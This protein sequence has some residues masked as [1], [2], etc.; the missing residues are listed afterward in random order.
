MPLLVT[1]VIVNLC[2]MDFSVCH[3]YLGVS[4][5][6]ESF[7]SMGVIHVHGSHSCPWESF[8]PRQEC[9]GSHSCLSISKC[10]SS[11]TGVIHTYSY[12][13]NITFCVMLSTAVSILEHC[14]GFPQLL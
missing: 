11:T 10:E 1:L 2:I 8:M 13:N 7:M 3:W 14:V 5:P 9:S 4:Y 12:D 6:R